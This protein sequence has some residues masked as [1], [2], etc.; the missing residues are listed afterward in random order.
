MLTSDAMSLNDLLQWIA[1]AIILAIVIFTAVRR[2]VRFRRRLKDGE[3]PDCGCCDGCG[4]HCALAD[5]R[6]HKK[7]T[8]KK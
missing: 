7:K 1:V 8:D 2:T 3:N 4:S 6:I 5:K